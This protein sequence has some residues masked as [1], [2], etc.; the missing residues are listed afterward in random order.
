M[1]TRWAGLSFCVVLLASAQ[2]AHETFSFTSTLKGLSYPPLARQARIQGTV[3]L[4]TLTGEHGKVAITVSNGYP[5]LV[6]VARQNLEQ[7]RFSEPLQKP[8][9][10]SYV[11]GLTEGSSG[12]QRRLRGDA[13]DRF[14]LRLFRRS[15]YKEEYYCEKFAE[16]GKGV[17]T[18]NHRVHR[19]R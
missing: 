18:S 11:F 9:M 2:Q 4:A 1:K 14:F 17:S 3:R 7:W 5:I 8:V 15:V 19:P 10:V 12:I 6:G 13:F 16:S